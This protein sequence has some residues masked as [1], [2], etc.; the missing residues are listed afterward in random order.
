VVLLLALSD[1][2]GTD[3][4]PAGLAVGGAVTATILFVRLASLG[5]RPGGGVRPRGHARGAAV[6]M[7]VGAVPQ[8]IAQIMYA[9]TLAFAARLD[10]GSVTL[11]SYGFFAAL[12]VIGAT[13]FPASIVLAAPLAQDWDRRAESLVPPLTEVFRA[14]LVLVAPVVALAALCGDELIE[15]VLGGSLSSHDAEAI[16]STFLILTGIVV[17]SIA[18]AVP[19]LAAFAAGRYSR[20]V[21]LAALTAGFHVLASLAAAQADRIQALAAVAS[22]DSVLFLALLVHMTWG[23]AAWGVGARLARELA[24][25]AVAAGVAFGPLGAAAAAAGSWPAEAAAW[26][27]GLGAFLALLAWRLPDHWLLALRMAEPV[28]AVR[29]RSSR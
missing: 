14:G 21:A 13:T 24:A 8:L 11:Y 26:V 16:V 9:V 15:L 5:Y 18:S 20:L 3:S 12:L 17:T 4:V 29:G 19:M 28:A 10:P 22:L 23:R 25:V 2:L 1:P 27:A 6:L 7:L